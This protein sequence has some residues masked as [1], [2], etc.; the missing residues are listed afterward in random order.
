LFDVEGIRGSIS[1]FNFDR[2]D[3]VNTFLAWGRQ[4][5]S[6]D[7]SNRE[8]NNNYTLAVK[9]TIYEWVVPAL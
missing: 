9:R 2:D 1:G 3:G 6:D 4:D 8:A 5:S 7:T